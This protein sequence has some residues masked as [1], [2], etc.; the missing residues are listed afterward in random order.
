[1]ESKTLSVLLVEDSADDAEL[2]MRALRDDTGEGGFSI[3]CLRVETAEAMQSAL[4]GG[5]WDV[6]LSDYNLPGFGAEEALSVLQASGH[7][8]PFIIVSAC[9]GEETAVSLMKA[10][11]HDFVMKGSLARLVPAVQRGLLEAETRRQFQHA[12]A[13]L[14][15]SEARFRVIASNLPGVVYQLLQQADGSVL[16][17]YVSDGS[18]ALF[19]LSPQALQDD[20][21]LFPN[22]ILPEDQTSYAQSMAASAAKLSTWNWEG[23]IRNS[24]R[25]NDQEIKWVNL[26]ASPRQ[27]NGGATLWDGI[28]TNITQNKLAAIEITH[29]HEQLAELTSYLQKVKEEECARIAREIHD[30][31]GGTLTAIK[32][33]M[34]LCANGANRGP[35][36][37]SKKTLSIESLVDQL[38]DSTRRIAMDL[39]PSILDCG[40]VA[41]IQ[42]QVKEFGERTGIACQVSCGSEEIPLD[43]DLSVEIFR[44]FQETLTNISKH[45]H[46]SRIRVRLAEKDGWVFLETTDNGRGITDPDLAKPQSFG[47]RGMRERC[48]QLGG[49]LRIAGTPAKGTTVTI[50]VPAN[51]MERQAGQPVTANLTLTAPRPGYL[52]QYRKISAPVKNRR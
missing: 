10:G 1:M 41:A 34:L 20:P 27:T 21:A 38:I 40:I 12:Q 48:Q 33:E 13:E 43:A 8:I 11:A 44:I 45:A 25:N 29:A 36:Y 4:A 52:R 19:G 50:C 17:P 15:Q 42:W 26:R 7:D 5:G 32:C 39:R 30:D 28:M 46:A 14:E 2:V 23:R 3:D 16:F 18:L 22:L 51:G 9:I 31:I 37:C 47:I 24:A 35:A 49:K 6:I